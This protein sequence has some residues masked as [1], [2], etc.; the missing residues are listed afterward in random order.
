[1][2]VWMAAK[3]TIGALRDLGMEDVCFIGGLAAKLYGND[4]EP[5]VS[6]ICKCRVDSILIR[7]RTIDEYRTW[8]S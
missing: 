8:T 5:N 7:D 3:A 6:V 4:R 1:M 2:S